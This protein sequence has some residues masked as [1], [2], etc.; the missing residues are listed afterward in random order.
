M[1]RKAEIPVGQMLYRTPCP[2]CGGKLR[3][4]FAWAT[5][6]G[7]GQICEDCGAA[8]A[9]S[10]VPLGGPPSLLFRVNPD[11][12]AEPRSPAS[13]YCSTTQHVLLCVGSC[14]DACTERERKC[15]GC[16]PGRG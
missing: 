8:W 14:Y 5:F 15:I 4:T 3:P 7:A 16:W 9:P 13:F 6:S 2:E 12:S 11:G 1:I 10:A